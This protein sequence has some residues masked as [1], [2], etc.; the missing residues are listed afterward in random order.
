M[1]QAILSEIYI[2]PVKSLAGIKVKK[3][4]VNEKGLLHPFSVM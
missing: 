3:W 2:Y 1:T 4:Q